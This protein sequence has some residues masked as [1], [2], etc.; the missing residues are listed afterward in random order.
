VS[1]ISKQSL[2]KPQEAPLDYYRVLKSCKAV[3]KSLKDELFQ[4]WT[5]LSHH[6]MRRTQA[7]GAL[8]RICALPGATEDQSQAAM[9]NYRL[10]DGAYESSVLLFNQMARKILQE[11]D[12]S[13]L[14]TEQRSHH[15]TTS[16]IVKPQ[17]S[18]PRDLFD[19]VDNFPTVHVNS[20][21][22]VL[23]QS[24]LDEATAIKTVVTRWEREQL[25]KVLITA[26]QAK[27]KNIASEN[28]KRLLKELREK[29]K[30]SEDKLQ[31]EN[32]LRR[33]SNWGNYDPAKTT[34][35]LYLKANQLQAT[36]GK[37]SGSMD[38]VPSSKAGGAVQSKTKRKWADLEESPVITG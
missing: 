8:R 18:V 24:G 3:G 13:G 11:A 32:R 27:V 1:L 12:K 31:R 28:L 17:N 29:K 14:G 21:I 23:L 19:K 15:S 6:T 38:K 20:E 7:L 5:R 37:S 33:A 25:R 10:A 9:N 16:G 36:V 35:A 30:L 4:S 34:K 22:S 26:D 2:Y